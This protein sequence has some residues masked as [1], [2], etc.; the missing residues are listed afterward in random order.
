[1]AQTVQSHLERTSLMHSKLK[2]RLAATSTSLPL[3]STRLLEALVAS[4]LQ[5]AL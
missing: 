2:I 3:P 1:M 5:A 4:K